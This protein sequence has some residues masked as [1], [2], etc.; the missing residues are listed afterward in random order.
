[1]RAR[2]GAGG[3]ER[4]MPFSGWLG[5]QIPSAGKLTRGAKLRTK[6]FRNS[7]AF[8][9]NYRGK[10]APLGPRHVLRRNPSTT[11]RD[12]LSG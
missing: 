5:H 3:D 8:D 9:P 7:G 4:P 10:G 1:M 12:D 6:R 11:A 2:G